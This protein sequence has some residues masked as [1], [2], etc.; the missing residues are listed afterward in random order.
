MTNDTIKISLTQA[1]A[2]TRWPC[3][4]CGGC[5]EKDPILAEGEQDLGPTEIGVG[6]KYRT[7]RVCDRCLKGTG[8]LSIDQRLENFASLLEAEAE[9]TRALIGRLKVPSHAEW[10]AACCEFNDALMREHEEANRRLASRKADDHHCEEI[11]F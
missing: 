1:C 5:T 4:V 9:L 2:W 6:R 8:G 3:H 7:V 10:E 11:P